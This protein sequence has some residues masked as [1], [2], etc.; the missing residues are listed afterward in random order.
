MWENNQL[1]VYNPHFLIFFYLRYYFSRLIH[2]AAIK[3]RMQWEIRSLWGMRKALAWDWSLKQSFLK[4]TSD[5]KDGAGRTF[6]SIYCFI[7]TLWLRR[8]HAAARTLGER[9]ENVDKRPFCAQIFYSIHLIERS[10]YLNY[11]FLFFSSLIYI[12]YLLTW[13]NVQINGGYVISGF[14]CICSTCLMIIT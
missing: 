12:L 8:L 4:Q 2:D 9:L 13:F 3:S 7:T 11:F 5:G 14:A 6:C 1:H 10:I